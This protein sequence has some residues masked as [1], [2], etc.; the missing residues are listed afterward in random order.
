M[1]SAD[2]VIFHCG[3]AH[4]DGKTGIASNKVRQ[5]RAAQVHERSEG[6][7][8]ETADPRRTVIRLLDESQAVRI[9]LEDKS[10]TGIPQPAV[11]AIRQAVQALRDVSIKRD[12]EGDFGHRT[13][14][15][16]NLD[17]FREALTVDF[18]QEA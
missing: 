5:T 15:L 12:N 9:I 7:C 4:R 11:T 8:V 10:N 17:A 3:P 14:I 6:T 16:A 13:A 1:R 2:A 18:Q